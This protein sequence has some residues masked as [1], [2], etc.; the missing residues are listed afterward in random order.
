MLRLQRPALRRSIREPELQAARLGQ[1]LEKGVR[2]LVVLVSIVVQNPIGVG[3]HHSRK[4][5]GPPRLPVK[6]ASV[7]QAES[8]GLAQLVVNCKGLDA[9]NLS[10][11][12]KSGVR[13]EDCVLP[14][15]EFTLTLATPERKNLF[16]SLAYSSS[17][18]SGL[19]A[20]VVRVPIAWERKALSA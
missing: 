18:Y 4:K 13:S 15:Q 16:Q 19:K 20:S 8:V 5:E 3:V 9:P 11:K 7:V 14:K 1:G 6:N 10:E 17:P 12:E 2:D